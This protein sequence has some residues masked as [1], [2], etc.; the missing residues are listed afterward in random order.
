MQADN[1][2]NELKNKIST[3]YSEVP[4]DIDHTLKSTFAIL[5][6][7]RRKKFVKKASVF[8]CC[9]L[10]IFISFVGTEF[11]K[12]AKVLGIDGKEAAL[13]L[14]GSSDSANIYADK[15]DEE[16]DCNGIS[17]KIT[18][19][20]YDGHRL[21]FRYEIESKDAALQG[22]EE[23]GGVIDEIK[24]NG[25]KI[26][27][28]VDGTSE[29]M[30]YCEDSHSIVGDFRVDYND[31]MINQI[32]IRKIISSI[33]F[34]KRYFEIKA[35]SR[36]NNKE[37]IWNIN[38]RI[39][40]DNVYGKNLIVGND[41]LIN[42]KTNENI[43]NFTI[44]D[45]TVTPVCI[46]VNGDIHIEKDYDDNSAQFIV[47]DQE[48]KEY[49][50]DTMEAGYTNRERTEGIFEFTIS[51]KP[52]TKIKSLTFI[53]CKNFIPSF[54]DDLG[55]DKENWNE[56][57]KKCDELIKQKKDRQIYVNEAAKIDIK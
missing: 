42:V 38:M 37:Y 50:S 7:R 45:I 31:P 46:Y 27:I 2:D 51:K 39:S 47:K 16:K 21:E 53:P 22:L 19:I 12:T 43:G 5:K 55:K 48:G 3:I 30:S 8:L 36:I 34:N 24:M 54:Y 18:K 44:K 56:Y 32:T 40:M 26:N 52:E 57:H 4:D 13:I 23:N 17:F 41:K 49:Y 29:G 6:V 25:Q 14:F 33:A 10:I 35:K 1:F 11:F 15:V 20:F 9:A 28:L